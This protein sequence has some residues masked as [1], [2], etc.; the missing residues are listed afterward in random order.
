VAAFHSRTA[1]SIVVRGRPADSG[2]SR[3]EEIRDEPDRG[4][5]V[6]FHDP[7]AG[8]WDD[9]FLHIRSGSAH[10]VRHHR[11]ERLLS[12]HSQYWHGQ[13]ALGHEGLVVDRI[14]IESFELLKPGVH[15]TGLGIKLRVVRAGSF[16]EFFRISGKF[17]PEAI[18]IYAF[19]SLY[20]TLGI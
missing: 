17:I 20:E 18:E 2:L 19:A 10:N 16:I 3:F 4:F 12:S 6:F 1:V 15:G 8:I 7:V 5:G 13:L 11:A 9:G 14:L